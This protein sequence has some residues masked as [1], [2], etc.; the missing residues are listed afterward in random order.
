MNIRI[1]RTTTNY[2]TFVYS[3]R[4]FVVGIGRLCQEPEWQ[5]QDQPAW[6]GGNFNN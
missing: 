4:S 5:P 1:I 6:G 3:A 2:Y